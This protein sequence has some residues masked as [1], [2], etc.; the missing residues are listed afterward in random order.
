MFLF[1][2]L[3]TFHFHRSHVVHD[4]CVFLCKTKQK[5]KQKNKK[6]REQKESHT[7]FLVTCVGYH[8]DVYKPTMLGLFTHFSKK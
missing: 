2:K 8:D 3:H 1:Y 4:P 7:T 5:Q 6:K